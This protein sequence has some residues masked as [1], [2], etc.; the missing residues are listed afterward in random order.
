MSVHPSLS[1]FQHPLVS[2]VQIYQCLWLGDKSGQDPQ[3]AHHMHLQEDHC[4][5]TET[6]ESFTHTYYRSV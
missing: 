6:V 3:N 4:R 2:V 1:V 5:P